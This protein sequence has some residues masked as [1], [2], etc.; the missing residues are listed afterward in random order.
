MQKTAHFLS[1]TMIFSGPMGRANPMI[2]ADHFV[3]WRMYILCEEFYVVLNYI[4]DCAIINCIFSLFTSS[5]K[6]K[7]ICARNIKNVHTHVHVHVSIVNQ[8]K[9]KQHL[10]K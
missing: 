10:C 1:K 2:V 6:L 8:I 4:Q 9:K 7:K 3:K 5:D